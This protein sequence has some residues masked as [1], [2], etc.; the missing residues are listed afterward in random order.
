MKAEF[1]HATLR[2]VYF[3]IER[4]AIQFDSVKRM[5]FVPTCMCKLYVVFGVTILKK[6]N[7]RGKRRN[8]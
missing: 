1:I 3:V 8:L 4:M 6:E 2:Q 7:F 5:S